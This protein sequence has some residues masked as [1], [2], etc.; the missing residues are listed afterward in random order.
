MRNFF[1]LSLLLTIGFFLNSCSST[2]KEKGS[3]DD[4]YAKSQTREAIIE[5]SGTLFRGGTKSQNDTQMADAQNRL[6]SG[7]GLLAKKE[8]STY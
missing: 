8:G 3:T 7:G 6:V 1:L 2:N 4:L 5:R